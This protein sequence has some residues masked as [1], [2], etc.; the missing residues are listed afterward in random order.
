MPFGLPSACATFPRALDTVIGAEM[1]PH[2]FA[3]LDDIVVIGTTKEQHVANLKKVF[4]RS[5]AANLKLYRKKCSF[6]RKS[7]DYLVSEEG[8]CTDPEK[9]EAIRNLR[10]P[11]NLKEMRQCLG[12]ASE[13]LRRVPF[14]CDI[15]RKTVFTANCR[16]ALRLLSLHC[17]KNSS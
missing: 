15:S 17:A 8:I 12:M 3:Y 9:I 1:E 2:V 7:L 14:R 4:C 10:A 16:V 6:F 11:T 5:R 13:L